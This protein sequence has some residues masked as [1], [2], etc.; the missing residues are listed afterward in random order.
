M[1]KHPIALQLYSLRDLAAQNFVEALELTA[2]LG[3]E[4]VEFAGYGGLPAGEMSDHLLRLGLKAVSS[5]VSFERLKDHLDEEI[6]Y[7]RS[8][9]NQTLVCPVPPRDFDRT[10]AENWRSFAR[11]LSELGKRAADGGFRLGYHNHSF[12]FAIVEAAYA[13]DLLLETADPRYV[14]AQLDLGWILHGGEDPVGYLRKH[15]GRTPL[16]HIKD[17]D[18]DNKQTDVGFGRLDLANVL[19]AAE[20]VGVEWIIL[21][22]EEYKISPPES[23]RAGL[24]SLRNA[25]NK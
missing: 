10:S 4:G 3:Y 20:D 14:F 17:F 12:E 11:E 13:L 21:E 25:Q 15:K 24:G 7:N 18:S 9:G 5:H 1:K 8:L 23:I 22:T 2:K 19:E 16:V 6:A